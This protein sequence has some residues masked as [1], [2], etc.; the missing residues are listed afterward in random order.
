MKPAGAHF[1]LRFFGRSRTPG[2]PSSSVNSIPSASN[3]AFTMVKGTAADARYLCA[4]LNTFDRADLL[5]TDHFAAPF[6]SSA[7]LGYR[8]ATWPSHRL[9]K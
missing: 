9:S 3:A 4:G 5:T 2:T 8:S 6:F 7:V 1:P